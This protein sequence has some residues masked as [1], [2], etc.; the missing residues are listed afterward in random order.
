MRE[1]DKCGVEWSGVEWSEEEGPKGKE[2]RRRGGIRSRT[3]TNKKVGKEHNLNMQS[4][5]LQEMAVLIRMKQEEQ[6]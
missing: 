2:A 4:K 1:G 3:N 5:H 6:K